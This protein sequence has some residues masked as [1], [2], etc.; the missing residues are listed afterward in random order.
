MA[1]HFIHWLEKSARLNRENRAGAAGHMLP[2]KSDRELC[3][4]STYSDLDDTFRISLKQDPGHV[5]GLLHPDKVLGRG[6][7]SSEIIGWRVKSPQRR[8]SKSPARRNF[9]RMVGCLRC[10][11]AKF[12]ISKIHG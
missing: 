12:Y 3:A 2:I 1:A 5:N 8:E 4:V 7:L 10:L 9:K 11:A 6:D